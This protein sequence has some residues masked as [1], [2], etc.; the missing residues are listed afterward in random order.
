MPSNALGVPRVGSA[1]GDMSRIT[2]LGLLGLPPILV[3]LAETPLALLA[4]VSLAAVTSLTP[5][6][7]STSSCSTRATE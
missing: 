2:P 3:F 4:V 5:V 1:S 6:A 7:V